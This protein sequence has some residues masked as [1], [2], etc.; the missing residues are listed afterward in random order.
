MSFKPTSRDDLSEILQHAQDN[1]VIDH[2]VH[3]I[4]DGAIHVGEMQVREIMVPRTQMEVIKSDQA[5]P[6]MLAQ[7]IK[8]KH[9]PV[10]CHR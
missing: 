10:P 2:D 7:I 5:F 9:S 1:E 6:D 4:I 3:K 8:T